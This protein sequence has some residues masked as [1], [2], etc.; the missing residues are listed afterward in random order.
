MTDSA[1]VP[2]IEILRCPSCSG[3]VPLGDGETV[4]CPFC[5]TEVPL[6]EPHRALR[7][8]ERA[9]RA[10]RKDAEAYY[11]ALA[12]PPNV[13]VRAFGRP[14]VGLALVILTPFIFIGS[15][16]LS[17]PLLD[18]FERIRH[19]SFLDVHPD[20][21]IAVYQCLFASIL[22][23]VFGLIGGF[24]RRTAVGRVL[25]RA[26]LIAK[27]PE[28]PGGPALCRSC[29]APLFVPTGAEAV[30]CTYCRSDNII[31]ISAADI[32]A[33]AVAQRGVQEALAEARRSGRDDLKHVRWSMFWRLLLLSTLF[34]FMWVPMIRA[35]GSIHDPTPWDD[36]RTDITPRYYS[37]VADCTNNFHRVAMR[38]GETFH[39]TRMNDERAPLEVDVEAHIPGSGIEYWQPLGPTL[40][41]PPGVPFDF[42]APHTGW[43]YLC[44]RGRATRITGTVVT[45]P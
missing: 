40:R 9:E 13:I 39:A 34:V 38:R 5:G 23:A 37:S 15:L 35:N 3:A 10:T 18:V 11:A 36:W 44:F 32:A 1:Q 31:A 24:A 7:D 14:G 17:V 28:R 2:A 21:W 27:P 45:R 30:R 22:L 12:K 20:K 4:R 6:P 42:V 26:A 16:L 41:W 43:M 29:N 33:Q 19:E 25:L 8:A